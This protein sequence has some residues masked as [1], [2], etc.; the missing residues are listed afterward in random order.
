VTL[1]GV[2]V[3]N[4]LTFKFVRSEFYFTLLCI[5]FEGGEVAS[6]CLLS[7]APLFL[8]SQMGGCDWWLNVPAV[9]SVGKDPTVHSWASA[10]LDVMEY[11]KI[12]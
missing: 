3:E 11:R 2:W 7:T 10:A 9:S 4:L 1:H 12:T 5:S 8:T 6:M